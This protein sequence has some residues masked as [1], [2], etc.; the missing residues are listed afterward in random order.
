MPLLD[1]REVLSKPFMR[2]AMT[3]LHWESHWE[4]QAMCE[5]NLRSCACPEI[6]TLAKRVIEICLLCR[7]VNKQALTG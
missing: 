6:Y 7:N 4:I 3:Q 5:A 1:G 2:E